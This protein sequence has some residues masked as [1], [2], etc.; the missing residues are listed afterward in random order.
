MIHAESREARR[1]LQHVE[2]SG[3]FQA[4]QNPADRLHEAGLRRCH[5]GTLILRLCRAALGNG[6][7]ELTPA[8]IERR[9]VEGLVVPVA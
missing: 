6:R 1:A 5:E 9:R 7:L 8:A 3:P 2:G 4:E